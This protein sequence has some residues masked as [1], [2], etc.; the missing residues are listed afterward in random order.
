MIIDYVL[1]LVYRKE[2]LPTHN[3]SSLRPANVY[4]YHQMTAANCGII[5]SSHFNAKHFIFLPLGRGRVS[6]QSQGYKGEVVATWRYQ[7][8]LLRPKCYCYVLEKLSVYVMIV[9]SFLNQLKTPSK[10]HNPKFFW[11]KFEICLFSSKSHKIQFFVILTSLK[12]IVTSNEGLLVLFYE[13][14]WKEEAHTYPPVPK[15]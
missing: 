7:L 4:F 13:F 9:I 15:F 8:L 3:R 11:R 2:W 5:I 6:C 12:V 14:Q 10:S 1:T